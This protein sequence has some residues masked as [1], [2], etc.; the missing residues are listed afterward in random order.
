MKKSRLLAYSL[1]LVISSFSF[2]GCLSSKSLTKTVK[3]VISDDCKTIKPVTV[4]NIILKTDGLLKSDSAVTVEKVSSFFIPAILVW[5]WENK[6]K[7]Q[8]N[9][10]YF[11]N[12]LVDEI[13]RQNDEFQLGKFLADRHL[14]I[15]IE[16]VPSV[17]EYEDNGF[18]YFAF[19]AYGYSSYEGIDPKDQRFQVSY[20]ILV[21]E[22]ELKKGVFTKYY[23]AP[24][25]DGW[26]SGSGLAKK[27]MKEVVNAYDN[28]CEQ[29]ISEIL[30]EL[31]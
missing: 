26:A 5:G 15:N 20:R 28:D 30:D 8:I 13:N 1:V 14:E 18:Y 2:S 19:F 6:L 10:N 3:S 23:N 29:C 25:K 7:C 9:D 16:S 4:G 22:T 27:Y 21:G 31:Y 17:F 12:V 11:V 24:F